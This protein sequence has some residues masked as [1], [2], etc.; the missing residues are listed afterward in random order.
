MSPLV[1]ILLKQRKRVIQKGDSK[2]HACLQDQI[3]KLIRENQV[4]TVKQEN[5]NQ[6]TGSKWWWSNV[7]SITGRNNRSR[8]VSAA[9]DPSDINV[10]FQSINT[11]PQ[12]TA[13]E[14]VEIPYGTRVPALSIN[15]ILHL[16]CK[17]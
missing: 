8:S 4:N 5:K 2:S 16:N 13:P 14:P 15:T 3:N 11:D 7:N 1:K 10:Y 9:F 12:Y 6:K 17:I